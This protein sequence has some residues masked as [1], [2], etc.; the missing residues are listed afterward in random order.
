MPTDHALPCFL[1][2]RFCGL[3]LPGALLAG[4][5]ATP[6][7]PQGTMPALEHILRDAPPAA[8]APVAV[9]DAAAGPVA[10]S[11]WWRSLSDPA[12]DQLIRLALADNPSLEQALARSDAARA[13]V[14]GSRARG[15]PTVGAGAAAGRARIPVGSG[16]SATETGRSSSADLSFQWEL[17][18]F[19]RLRAGRLAAQARLDA[20]GADAD[21]MRIALTAQIA[22]E[23]LSWRASSYAYQSKRAVAASFETVRGMTERLLAAGIVAPVELGNAEMLLS[24]ALRDA[25]TEYAQCS[26]HLHAL[27]ALSGLD[28]AALRPVLARA[29]GRGLALPAEP[30]FDAV[31]AAYPATGAAVPELVVMPEVADPVLLLPASVLA[32]HP[33]IVSAQREADAAWADI[34]QAR[35]DRWPRL[36]LSALL[37]RQWLAAGAMAQ[38]VTSW[39]A[40]PAL[41]AVL[42]DGGAG[43]AAVS[44]AEAHYR[45]ALARL[46]GAVRASV[47]EI[48]DALTGLESSGIA[49][50]RARQ[51]MQASLQLLRAMQS[52]W[53][54]GAADLFQLEAA[55][56]QF[57][58]SRNDMVASSLERNL[59]WVALLRA[60]GNHSLPA[61]PANSRNPHA[62]LPPSLD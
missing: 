47:Q 20:R 21:A 10:D 39:S 56:R 38:S 51:D 9:S 36:D 23:L 57:T 59:A 29:P 45:D 22:D 13:D 40:G 44:V 8:G 54:Q 35:A 27:G 33:A 30:H 60:T 24:A 3:L 46:Q 26:R 7:S 53:G 6:P 50:D 14:V 17:D 41:S 52:R 16:G 25:A 61:T 58:L 2:V 18:L 49:L 31:P 32:Q 62:A 37:S 42:Y 1:S 4:C 11:E 48:E 15:L 28:A 5:A 55:R 12:L 43:H 19:G 34:D